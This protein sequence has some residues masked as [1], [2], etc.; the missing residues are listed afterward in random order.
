MTKK[1][2]T[3]WFS[4]IVIGIALGL[5]IQ[6]VRAWTEPTSAPPDGN[7]GAPINTSDL[8]QTKEGDLKSGGTITASKFCLGASCITSW[9]TM[10]IGPLYS[11]GRW[12][13]DSHGD[14][15]LYW[16]AYHH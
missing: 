2:L 13:S 1:Q 9:P 7:L 16:D 8:A 5:A 4:V 6:F 14:M 3:Y 15:V 10:S 12:A 11:D